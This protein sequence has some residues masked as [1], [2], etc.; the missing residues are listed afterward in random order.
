MRTVQAPRNSSTVAAVAGFVF[1][2]GMLSPAFAQSAGEAS[3]RGAP[4]AARVDQIAAWLPEKPRGP[5]RPI[6]DR[7]AWNRL[8]RNSRA[9]DVI[10]R[11]E[12]FAK[13]PPPELPD[14]LYLDFSRT[15]N[16]DH[17]QRKLSDRRN[18][19]E[20][21]VLA[22][23]LE[24]RGRFLPAIEK[25]LQAC[26][27][28]KS[29]LLPAHD[30][31]LAN[32]HGKI[33]EIDLASS[34]NAATLATIDYWLGH[35]LSRNTRDRLHHELRRRTFD[36]FTGM[37]RHGKPWMWWL[38]TT[39]NWNAVCLAGVTIAATTAIDDRHE[40]AFFVASA[41]KY[42]RN[43]LSGFT[44]DGYCSEGLGYWNYGFG[45]FLLLAE[46][47]LQATGGKLD[48]LRDPKIE[49]VARFASRL[50][51]APGVYPAFADCHVEA[52]PEGW[53]LAYVN[54]HFGFGWDVASGQG[55]LPVGLSS[56]L[57]EFGLL[58][59]PS[60][61][62]SHATKATGTARPPRDWFDR[63]GILICRPA[64]DSPHALAVALKGGH[65]AE[66]H[67]HNDVGSFVVVLGKATPILDPGAE[68][69]TARTFSAHRYDSNVLNSFGHPVP[70]VAGKLQKEGRSA[71]A[72]VRKTSFTD[73][74]DTLVL[75][76]RSC[77]DVPGLKKLQRTFVYSRQGR[78]ALSINDE[79]EMATPESFETALITF[80]PWKQTGPRAIR[81]GEGDSAVDVAID[82]HG[83]PFQIKAEEI[84]EDLPGKRIPTRIGIA[85]SRRVTTARILLSVRPATALRITPARKM[86]KPPA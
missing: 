26:F 55:D 62:S 59:F 6:D 28:E 2:A 3:Q 30:G 54:R 22:E 73:K 65:N 32:F 69:Y 56:D 72:K 47:L 77:Y 75:D 52:H 23:C 57:F 34:A 39:N 49:K 70:R 13:S 66:H 17:Y 10:R 20:T 27:E 16:R 45:H 4:D 9:R 25:A 14:E 71:E 85:L 21:L 53:I 78:G 38:T 41:E 37:V 19:M 76:I 24:N 79:V 83:A 46:D 31:R 44:A 8:A 33:M 42:V 29:W 61:R 5:G 86:R 35:K 81:I 50:E 67:N 36:P 60:S 43:F 15:G 40:R 80:A 64:A 18:R 51:I 48:L 82:T 1:L 63:A 84:H 11:A 7:E 74:E 58:T 12:R 68:V